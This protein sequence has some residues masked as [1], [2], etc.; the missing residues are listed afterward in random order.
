M[1]VDEEVGWTWSGGMGEVERRC[2]WWRCIFYVFDTGGQTGGL[3][4]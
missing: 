4:I 1:W 3:R 2:S